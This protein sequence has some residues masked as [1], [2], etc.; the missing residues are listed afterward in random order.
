MADAGDDRRSRS[1]RRRPRAARSSRRSPRRSPAR[2]PRRSSSGQDD[3]QIRPKSAPVR[4]TAAPGLADATQSPEGLPRMRTLPP[5]FIKSV[6]QGDKYI[7]IIDG[8]PM[9]IATPYFCTWCHAQCFGSSIDTHVMSKKHKGKSA[10]GEVEWQESSET[11]QSSGHQLQF[12]AGHPEQAHVGFV[13]GGVLQG[14][15]S[16][17]FNFPPPPPS[18]L[19]APTLFPP[20]HLQASEHLPVPAHRAGRTGDAELISD[21]TDHC[22]SMAKQAVQDFLR[23]DGRVMIEN[24]VLETLLRVGVPATPSSSSSSAAP[25]AVQI[26]PPPAPPS[27]PKYY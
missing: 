26:P 23:G 19:T 16:G 21:L 11:A 1:L 6:V 27:R 4:L 5:G 22:A 2:P 25:R 20:V 8:V 15:L 7:V 9:E 14:P 18:D 24:I 3:L 12:T 10:N 17:I 13:P